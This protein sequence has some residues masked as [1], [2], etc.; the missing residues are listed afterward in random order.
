MY[1]THLSASLQNWNKLPHESQRHSHIKHIHYISVNN[2]RH[3]TFY[4]IG[5]FQWSLTRKF[6]CKWSIFSNKN[7]NSTEFIIADLW[8]PSSTNLN[9]MDHEIYGTLQS[10][11][12]AWVS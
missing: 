10:E 9:P 8:F 6:P 11:Y 7:S 3:L 12:C 2:K 5:K 4:V 1:I